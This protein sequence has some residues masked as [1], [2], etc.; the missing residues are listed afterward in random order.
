M[1]PITCNRGKEPIIPVDVDTQTD[2]E[3]SS[4]SSPSLNLSP[5]KNARESTKVKSCKRPLHLPALNDAFSGTSRMARREEGMRQNQPVQAPWNA[6]VLP[7]G[8]MPPVLPSDMIPSV[9][10]MA[11]SLYTAYIL[12]SHTRRHALFAPRTTHS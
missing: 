6:L 5:K 9:S 8:T 12:N 1:H 7:K 11:S 3:L 2:D 10:Y 4:G